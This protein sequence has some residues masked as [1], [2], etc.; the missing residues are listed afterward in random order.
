MTENQLTIAA[1]LAET[2]TDIQGKV[3][4]PMTE[5]QKDEFRAE[6]QRFVRE[7]VSHEHRGPHL[8]R[9]RSL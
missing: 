3:G 1:L 4:G 2:W 6:C 5:E 7:R 8:E 9:P